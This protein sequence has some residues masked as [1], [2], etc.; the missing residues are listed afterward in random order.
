MVI[1]QT[2]D[3]TK[4]KQMEKAIQK[5]LHQR[6]LSGEDVGRLMILDLLAAYKNLS[7]G[8]NGTG[9]LTDQEKINLVHNLTNFGDIQQYNDFRGVHDFLSSAGAVFESYAKTYETYY[10]KLFHLLTNMKYAE[11]QNN[12]IKPAIMTKIQ[13]EN[14]L[15]SN[16]QAPIGGISVLQ[17]YPAHMQLN[18][19]E[20]GFYCEPQSMIQ[21]DFTAENVLLNYSN[22]IKE[23]TDGLKDMLSEC[24][25]RRKAMELIGRF[26]KIRDVKILIGSIDEEKITL[27]NRLMLDAVNSINGL[28]IRNNVQAGELKHKFYDMLRP[29]N[30]A[31][32]EPTTTAITKARRVISFPFIKNNSETFVAVLK[33]DWRNDDG[34]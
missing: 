15:K 27:L 14:F 3:N 10:L 7:D 16:T 22:F 31:E 25:A 33:K 32:F 6:A 5:L 11:E 19:D 20:N 1:Q 9:V 23:M 29:I 24:C 17:D 30:S 13:Y 28:T 4:E 21:Q 26:I 2:P 18:I 34:K 8:G 12:T